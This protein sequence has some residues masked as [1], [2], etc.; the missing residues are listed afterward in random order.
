MP[1]QRLTFVGNDLWEFRST[2]A[3]KSDSR[4]QPRRENCSK[5]F[6]ELDL[7]KVLIPPA[8]FSG[9]VPL[10]KLTNYGDAERIIES[11]Y[12]IV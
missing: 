1:V 7:D 8:C 9:P 3:L 4:P 2:K 10:A 11:K 6:H 5:I 12:Y